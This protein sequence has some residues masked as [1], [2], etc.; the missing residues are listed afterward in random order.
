VLPLLLLIVTGTLHAQQPAPPRRVTDR[1]PCSVVQLQQ[2]CLL[3][4]GSGMP[5]PDPE[6]SGPAYAVVIGERT[7][8]FDAGA[9]VMRRAAA[10]GLHINGFTAAFLTHLHT[11]HTL[12]LPDVLFT[13]WTMGRRGPF[14]LIGPPGTDAMVHH[15]LAA[16]QEDIR[17]RIGGGERG[18]PA[19]PGVNV[20]ETTGGV[21]YDSAGVRIIAIPVRHGDFAVALGFRIELPTRVIVLSGD[22]APSEALAEA[23]RGA[24]LLVHEAYPEVRLAAEDRPG[25]EQWP[26]YMRSV[27]TSDVE[28]G[29]M[30]ALAGVKSVLLS[31]IVWMGGTEEE[32]IAGV[33]RGGFTGTVRVAQDL[34]GY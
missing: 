5:V 14:P 19:G 23:A 15:L 2:G 29:A 24:D 9:G 21:V 1:S 30:A 25:G 22:T 16:W 32:I 3:V 11:D 13:T 34:A 4:L 20:Q 18:Q 31:H 8:L 10:A 7:F 17:V 6:R 12:G 27:H 33:R 26:E 28:I